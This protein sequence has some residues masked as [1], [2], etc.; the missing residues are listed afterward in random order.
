M[1]KM[2]C[3]ECDEVREDEDIRG[4]NCFKCGQ[5]LTEEKEMEREMDALETGK[6]LQEIKR[7][8]PN[9]SEA[10]RWML[11]LWEYATGLRKWDTGKEWVCEEHPH[12]P[13]EHDTG[14]MKECKLVDCPA[15]GMCP[16]TQVK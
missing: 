11:L 15:P 4:G 5:P 16:M 6:K 9:T 14:E 7:A 12:L 3:E 13:Y 2:Y 8:F 1:S 10:L